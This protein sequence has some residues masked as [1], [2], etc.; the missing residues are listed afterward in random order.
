MKRYFYLLTLVFISACGEDDSAKGDQFYEMRQY[1][2]AIEAY[3]EH[4]KLK[5]VHVKSIYNRGRAYE[6]LGQFEKALADFNRV[7]EI[8]PSNAN[9]HLSIGNDYYR[10]KDYQNAAF[11]YEKASTLS[12]GNVQALFLKGRAY[13]QQGMFDEAISAY[14]AA[15]SEDKNYG[16]TYLYRAALYLSLN[17][18]N[19]ACADLRIAKSLGVQAAEASLAKHC[20]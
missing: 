14:N 8:D 1:A 20:K 9:A 18:K 15:I 5:P 11:F 3:N 10:N 7:I 2:K 4:L 13:H 17:R 6:E 19:Q 16:D 12:K